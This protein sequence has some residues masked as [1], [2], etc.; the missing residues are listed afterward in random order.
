MKW[1]YTELADLDPLDRKYSQAEEREATSIGL[2]ILSNSKFSP[3]AM[4]TFWQ[5]IQA[6]ETLQQ[7]AKPLS[8]SMSPQER[9]VMVKDLLQQLSENQNQISNNKISQNTH[10][11]S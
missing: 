7:K 10:P 3:N 11:D 8:R 9:V 2:L 6:N 1:I 5:R 4:L